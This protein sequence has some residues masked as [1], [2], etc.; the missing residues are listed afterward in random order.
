[1]LCLDGLGIFLVIIRVH[2]SQSYLHL[3]TFLLIALHFIAPH[4]WFSVAHCVHHP[5]RSS[6]Y[7]FV[8]KMFLAFGHGRTWKSQVPLGDWCCNRP[9]SHQ[10]I[11]VNGALS[12]LL[13]LDRV[14][15][16]FKAVAGAGR[17]VVIHNPRLTLRVRVCVCAC[18]CMRACVCGCGCVCV[19]VCV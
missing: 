3:H 5:L 18:P 12:Q 8:A 6:L 16:R 1:M 11:L 19:C 17:E 10:R 4:P 2:V 7:G 14:R 15:K 13:S 9:V